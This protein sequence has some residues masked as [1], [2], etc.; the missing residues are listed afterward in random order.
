MMFLTPQSYTVEISAV[1]IFYK[2]SWIDTSFYR[3]LTQRSDSCG[4][5][6]LSPDTIGAFG[7]APCTVYVATRA[8]PYT[9]SAQTAHTAYSDLL[10][11]QHQC[12]IFQDLDIGDSYLDF[13]GGSYCLLMGQYPSCMDFV[14]C[15]NANRGHWYTD[16]PLIRIGKF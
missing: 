12:R 2:E 15:S 13:G 8:A 11:S 6:Q 5:G 3:I 14:H 7:Q 1:D 4:T 10:S 9:Y 16:G